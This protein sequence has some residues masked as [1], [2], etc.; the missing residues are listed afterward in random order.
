MVLLKF[1]AVISNRLATRAAVIVCQ[2]VGLDAL[3]VVAPTDERVGM[4]TRS[5]HASPLDVNAQAAAV[6]FTHAE[7][8]FI[9]T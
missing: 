3:G 9:S 8:P 2:E 7:A 1:N 4:Q 6:R 5:M